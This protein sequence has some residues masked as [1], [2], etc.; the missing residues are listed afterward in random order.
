MHEL[1]HNLGLRHG[2]ND[3]LNCKPNYPSIQSY[4]LQMANTISDRPLDLSR[5]KFLTLTESQ[6]NEGAGIGGFPLG[7]STAPTT[8]RVAFG[9]LVGSPA[10][11][12]VVTVS[13][14]GA[15]NWNKDTDF[16]DASVIRD[17]SNMTSITGGCSP[18]SGQTLEGFNDWAN[19]Q[20]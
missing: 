12:T 11:P 7:Y 18:L 10:K 2:G 6:L 13:S 14:S 1:A 5:Q 9:P 3:N 20:F 4:H 19:I 15:I 8:G 16:S 17:V